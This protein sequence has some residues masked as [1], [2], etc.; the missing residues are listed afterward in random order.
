MQCVCISPSLLTAVL[1]SSSSSS[2]FTPFAALHIIKLALVMFLLL[3][4]YMLH[5]IDT[6]FQQFSRCVGSPVEWATRKV[7]R[8]SS[9]S[10]SG[11]RSGTGNAKFDQ[12]VSNS[13]RVVIPR[14]KH[15]LVAVN[16]Q[17]IQ[18]DNW[19]IKSAPLGGRVRR[20]QSGAPPP[21]PQVLLMWWRQT[22]YVLYPSAVMSHCSQSVS[23]PLQPVSQSATAVS[24]LITTVTVHWKATKW[25]KVRK[26]CGN[27]SRTNQIRPCVW[28]WAG[29]WRKVQLCAVCCAALRLRAVAYSVC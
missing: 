26:P 27:F 2:H 12:N 7:R 24:R 6:E 25:N 17:R 16:L 13:F 20:L 11:W 15:K 10:V 29:E 22:F 28:N 23:Q 5:S 9:V 14:D 4:V 18:I 19:H 1:L 21:P 3:P 8:K